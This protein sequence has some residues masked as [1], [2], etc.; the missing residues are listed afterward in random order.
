MLAA[1]DAAAQ[2][3]GSPSAEP[4]GWLERLSLLVVAVA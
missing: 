4:T 1:T 2:L 3:G